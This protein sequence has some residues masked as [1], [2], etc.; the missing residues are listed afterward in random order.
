MKE[1]WKGALRLRYEER[2]ELKQLL[3][4]YARPRDIS[5]R[6]WTALIKGEHITMSGHTLACLIDC[7]GFP[8]ISKILG[9]AVGFEETIFEAWK[10]RSELGETV[11]LE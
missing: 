4:T 5:F 10:I 1:E 6:V 9:S 3:W 11:T 8:V 7:I 2:Q